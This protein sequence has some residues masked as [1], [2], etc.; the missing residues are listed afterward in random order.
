[1]KNGV[2]REKRRRRDVGKERERRGGEQGKEQS[3]GGHGLG[4]KGAAAGVGEGPKAQWKTQRDD[5]ATASDD[6]PPL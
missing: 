1:M 3:G 2:I 5:M 4:R 6:F